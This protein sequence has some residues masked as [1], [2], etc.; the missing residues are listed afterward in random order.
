MHRIPPLPEW[1][2]EAK[3]A[4]AALIMLIV[5][6]IALVGIASSAP[7]P[8]RYQAQVEL[9]R[10]LAFDPRMSV[11]GRTACASCHNPAM[12]TTDHRRVAVGM[13]GSTVNGI[14]Y[15]DGIKGERNSPVWWECADKGRQFYDERAD[16]LRDQCLMPTLNPK[17]MGQPSL[18]AVRNSIARIDG[19]GP[20]FVAAFGDGDV[21]IDRMRVA[22]VQFLGTIHSVDCGADRHYTADQTND[23]LFPYHPGWPLFKAHCIRC[24]R[25]DSDWR[26][27]RMHNLGVSVRT[28]PSNPDQMRQGITGDPAD[29]GLTETATLREIQDSYP[30]M[31]DG[32]FRTIDGVVDFYLSGCRWR[33]GG[34]WKT[35]P[36]R[37]QAVRDPIPH[38][39]QQRADLIDFLKTQ[40]SGTK[41]PLPTPRLP[42]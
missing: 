6:L 3:R 30:Y 25:G 12:S 21:T 20:L 15:P 7:R 26:D 18:Q 16:S 28:N 24:H 27:G 41:T 37:D 11:D 31:H 9:G 32:S 39:A 42:K 34:K 19:Y 35:D 10:C 17:E 23:Q 36:K 40:F 1:S 13:I 5:L 29:F 33:R 4:L 22:L 2:E 38:T 14:N 8:S